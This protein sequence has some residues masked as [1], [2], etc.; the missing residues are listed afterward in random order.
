MFK[1]TVTK[2]KK[3]IRVRHFGTKKK[4]EQYEDDQ[5]KH[6]IIASMCNFKI[7]EPP[8]KPKE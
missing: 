7:E 1:V 5:Y 4:A 3:V 2:D 8:T 6:N